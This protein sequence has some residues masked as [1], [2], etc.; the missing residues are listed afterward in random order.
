MKYKVLAKRHLAK[1]VSYRILSTG[2]G[3]LVMW[4]VTGSIKIGAAFGFAEMLLKPA[5]YYL[6]E[7]AW[8]RWIKFGVVPEKESKKKTPL[9]TDDKVK[10]E[11]KVIEDTP[12]ETPSPTPKPKVKKVLNYSSNR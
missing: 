3:F 5:L 4:Y 1:T 6:H 8:Y 12:L 11:I 2:I 9:P 7:R 10:T